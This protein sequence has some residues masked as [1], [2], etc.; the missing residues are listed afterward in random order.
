MLT[1]FYRVI[2][3][4]IKRLHDLDLRGWW[5]L[6]FVPIASLVLGAGMQFVAGTAGANRF[7]ANSRG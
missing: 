1:C 6:V 4:S 3:Q 7:G 5:L 2:T